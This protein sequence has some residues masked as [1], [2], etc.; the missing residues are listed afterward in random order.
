MQQT[1][2]IDNK[3]ISNIFFN[4][5]EFIEWYHE[6]GLYKYVGLFRGGYCE[7]KN[8][9]KYSDAVTNIKCRMC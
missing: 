4:L 8:I 2:K 5:L 3:V 9:Y 1:K 6:M 7:M